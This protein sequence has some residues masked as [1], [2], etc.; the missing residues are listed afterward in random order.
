MKCPPNRVKSTPRVTSAASAEAYDAYLKGLYHWYKLSREGLDTAE[1]Y[2]ELALARDPN[3]ARAY[4]GIALLWMGRNQMGFSLPVEGVPKARAAALRAV[5][6]DDALAEAHYVLASL[7]TWADWN[8]ETA[9]RE[10]KRTIELNPGF[11]DAHIYYSHF[12]NIMH[13][14]D[15]AMAEAARALELD[16]FNA[17]FHS[18]Y[19]VDLV[20][21]YR[22]DEALA[23][24]ETVLEANPT[25]LLA[26]FGLVSVH[27]HKREYKQALNSVNRLAKVQGYGEVTT[28]LAQ[29]AEEADYSKT[30]NLAADILAARSRET[31]VLPTDIAIWYAYAGDTDACLEWLDRA[32]QVQDPALPYL[33]IPDYDGVR[34]DSRFVALM[35]RMNLPQ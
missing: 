13:R 12:L 31:F 11:A 24:F 15:E 23:E 18:L 1:R 25:D 2:F 21:A 6:L 7:N 30:M 16:P 35:K 5:E 34:N 14:P 9:E 33:W 22:F 3:Y 19:G 8:W 26:L 28:L 4:V 29:T 17:L 10:F 27:H 20:F 32:Y